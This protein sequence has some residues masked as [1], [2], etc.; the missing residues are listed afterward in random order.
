MPRTAEDVENYLLALNRTFENDKGTYVVSVGADSP[1]VAIRVAPPIV[2]IRVD[3]GP[4][5]GDAAHQAKLF[6]RLLEFN[7]TDLMHAAYGV[8]GNRMVLSA[9]LELE[10]LDQNELEATLSDIDVALARHISELR[11]LAGNNG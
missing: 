4:V 9:G 7:A 8:S 1:P 2:A 11:Q 3:I 5:P 6:R 10:N